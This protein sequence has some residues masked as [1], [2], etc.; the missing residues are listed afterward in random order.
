MSSFSFA[1]CSAT[2][3]PCVVKDRT[4]LAAPREDEE[5][6]GPKDGEKGETA[7]DALATLRLQDSLINLD[8][9]V[10][11]LDREPSLLRESQ[12]GTILVVMKLHLP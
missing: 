6:G 3:A 2:E 7:E 10:E 1:D 5:L 11:R 8:G 4:H 9:G 12:H